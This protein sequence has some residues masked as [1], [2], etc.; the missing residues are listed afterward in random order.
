MSL[1]SNMTKHQS[2]FVP[3]IG[4]HENI[5]DI[6]LRRPLLDWL[7]AEGTVH[8]FV[9]KA[10]PGYSE[11][12]GVRSDDVVYHSFLAWYWA[13]LKSA[14]RGRA[15]YAFKPGEIQL[16]FKGLKEHVS[17]LPLLALLRLRGGRVVRVGSGAR[18][19]SRLPMWLMK[20][21]VWFSDL[22]MWRDARTT[23]Y[24]GA[25]TTM[26]DLGFADGVEDS[27]M[28][29]DTERD[30][31]VLSMRG[32]RPD[33]SDQWV[34]AVRAFAARRSLSI[35]VV[36]QVHRDSALSQNLA[37]R[38][39]ANLLDW[40]GTAHDQQEQAL[41]AL[42]DKAAVAISDRLHVLIAAFTHGAV[43]VGLLT[44]DSDKIE[45]HFNAAGLEGVCVTTQGLDAAAICQCLDE[46][47]ADRARF[48]QGRAKARSRLEAVR[49]QIATLLSGR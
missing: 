12:L 34:E 7:R 49:Q 23:T 39:S 2:I 43:P 13:G 6:I 25:G 32:D 24:M 20:P 10:P 29:P 30:V 47:T 27:A 36:T 1:H 33:L 4:Q 21:S 17:M 9:G 46:I 28:A 15:H 22:V 26:P 45:R 48:A 3:M 44:Y 16:T 11:A 42:Y 18:N 19:F 31:L 37:R 41:R 8:T 38:L 40:D 35:W 14:V 5:G